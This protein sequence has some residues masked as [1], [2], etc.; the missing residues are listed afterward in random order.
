MKELI[1]Y[2]RFDALIDVTWAF[3][4]GQWEIVDIT[5]FSNDTEIFDC[6]AVLF[7]LYLHLIESKYEQ[8]R[9]RAK[10]VLDYL[11]RF[12]KQ[13]SIVRLNESAASLGMKSPLEIARYGRTLLHPAFT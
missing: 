9:Q 4:H 10:G 13:H 12:Q 1:G 8:S 7:A 11:N 5:Q 2:T 3:L 6:F